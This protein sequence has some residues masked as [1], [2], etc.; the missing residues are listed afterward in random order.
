MGHPYG[1]NGMPVYT[2]IV[3]GEPGTAA[4]FNT[5]FAELEAALSVGSTDFANL[6]TFTTLSG[7]QPTITINSINQTYS[8]IQ[9]IAL[10]RSDVVATTSNLVLQFNGDSTVGNY[11]TRRVTHAAAV[12]TAEQLGAGFAGHDL[13][14]MIL[15]ASAPA[16][17]YAVLDLRIFRY[18]D[19]GT[20]NILFDAYAHS[21]NTA[22]G[23]L[24]YAGGGSYRGGAAITSITLSATG[25]NFVSGTQYALYGVK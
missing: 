12:S 22:G 1:E 15:G 9:L 2:P 21:A 6:V 5:R 7:S 4:T 8:I 10:M 13:S 18:T 17:H 19:T 11:W 24:Y 23:M 20:R 16:S 3:D 25:G 14:G